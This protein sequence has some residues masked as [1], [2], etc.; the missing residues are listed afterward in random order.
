MWTLRYAN[1]I[2]IS[3]SAVTVPKSTGVFLNDVIITDL[4]LTDGTR[5]AAGNSGI[6]VPMSSGWAITYNTQSY[7]FNLYK[8]VVDQSYLD[9][10]S[11]TTFNF[12]IS[13]S[14]PVSVQQMVYIPG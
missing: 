2:N 6:F 8:T 11:G 14:G 12:L 7:H 4:V 9:L 5:S 10:A 13:K 1:Q 3:G